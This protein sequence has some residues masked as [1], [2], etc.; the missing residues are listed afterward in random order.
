MRRHS[1]K[2]NLKGGEKGRIKKTKATGGVEVF[3]PGIKLN[4]SL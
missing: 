2:S 3:T 1:K 4:F